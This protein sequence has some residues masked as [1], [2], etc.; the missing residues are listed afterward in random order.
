MPTYVYMGMY[1]YGAYH[2]HVHIHVH[3][4][5][6]ENFSMFYI[7]VQ[8]QQ[9]GLVRRAQ[10]KETLLETLFSPEASVI[11]ILWGKCGLSP[12]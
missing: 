9:F 4:G 8:K 11:D 7:Y 6:I 10:K 2:V 3:M 1:M 12:C 5:A